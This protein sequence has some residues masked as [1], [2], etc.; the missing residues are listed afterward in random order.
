MKPRL[1]LVL[2][3]AAVCG[4]PLGAALFRVWVHQD[5]VLLGYSLSEAERRRFELQDA[6]REME[7]EVAAARSPERLT[8][9][10]HDI[11]MHRPAPHEIIGA[12][13]EAR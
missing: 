7:V 3:L 10:A 8:G 1:L 12:G 13:E 2:W 4:A 11:G 6:L 5:V 9:L